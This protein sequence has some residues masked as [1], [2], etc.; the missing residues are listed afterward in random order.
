[1]SF[2]GGPHG[3]IKRDYYSG[4][5][6]LAEEIRAMLAAAPQSKVG[7]LTRAAQDV[8]AERRRQVESEGWTPEHDDE[9]APRMLA[10]AGACYAIFWMNES[11]SPLSI[12]PWDESWWKPSEDPRRNWIKATALMLAEIERYDRA[13][14]QPK[15][16]E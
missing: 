7:E 13:D 9:H 8:L 10:T 4:L 1:M 2:G 15:G 12:W 14:Q 3:E 6:E 16:G 11:S 5:I